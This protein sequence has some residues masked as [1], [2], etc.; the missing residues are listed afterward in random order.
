MS[1]FFSFFF[2]QKKQLYLFAHLRDLYCTN[3]KTESTHYDAAVHRD[4]HVKTTL[5]NARLCQTIEF[6]SL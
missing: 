4:E 1:R 6:S 2:W 3:D 5:D